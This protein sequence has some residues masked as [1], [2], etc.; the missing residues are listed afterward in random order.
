MVGVIEF[1]LGCFV[2]VLIVPAMIRVCIRG[3]FEEKRVYLRTMLSFETEKEK[4]I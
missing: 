1:A 2:M 4:E 3:Y